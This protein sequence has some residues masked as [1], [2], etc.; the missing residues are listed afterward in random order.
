MPEDWRKADVTPTYEK[1][2]KDDTGDYWPI[3]LTLVPSKAMEW[4]FLGAATS[5]MK[6]SWEKSARTHQ[7]QIMH[8][9]PDC[10]LRLLVTS[11]VDVEQ[12]VD[13]FY[14][15]FTKAFYTFCHCLLLRIWCV[16]VQTSGLGC[17]TA[18][19]GG[20]YLAPFQTGNLSQEG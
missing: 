9:Q 1:R 18:P 8:D 17:Q 20:W 3:T 7:G 16:M 12:A 10:I 2:L 19:T 4:T 15:S 13:V 6:Q 5:Q 11:S 14:L